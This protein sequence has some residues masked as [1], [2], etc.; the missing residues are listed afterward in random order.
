M[1]NDFLKTFLADHPMMGIEG[2]MPELGQT[3]GVD[4]PEWVR[5][6]PIY[7]IFVRNFSQEGTF[8]AVKDKLP[9]LKDLGIKT[10]WLMPIHPIGLKDR[11]GTM[12]S[13]YAIADYM[14]IEPSLGSKADF[15]DLVAAVHQA[16]MR[17]ILDL[18]INHT[19][20]DHPWHKT[21]PAFYL[22]PGKSEGVRKVAE[23]SDITDLNYDNS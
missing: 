7:E 16:D 8:Q 21:H 5:E 6:G 11:K 15:K 22:Y 18:V 2:N 4:L 17:L 1:M 13:P 19:G 9:Y 10:L 14:E 12:G 3:P 20:N 23:W